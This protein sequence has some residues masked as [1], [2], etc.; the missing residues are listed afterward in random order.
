[1]VAFHHLK[2]LLAVALVFG[3]MCDVR[4]GLQSPGKKQQ[5]QEPA[6]EMAPSSV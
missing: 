5:H 3:I 6:A 2:V 1:M 4:F